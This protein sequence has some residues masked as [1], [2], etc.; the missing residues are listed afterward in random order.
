MKLCNFYIIDTISTSVVISF[1]MEC[2]EN[3]LLTWKIRTVGSA[4]GNADA[5]LQ[6][7]KKLPAA[8]TG[9]FAG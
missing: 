4:F 3:G 8:R 9:R 1:A 5:M 7:V 2:F 6:M